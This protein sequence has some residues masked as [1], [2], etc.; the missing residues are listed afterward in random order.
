M[1]AENSFGGGRE[2]PAKLSPIFRVL[3]AVEVP[4][5]VLRYAPVQIVAYVF[6]ELCIF[7]AFGILIHDKNNQEP[8]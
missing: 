1:L 5:V 8:R 4:E 2:L 3:F 7:R 6:F